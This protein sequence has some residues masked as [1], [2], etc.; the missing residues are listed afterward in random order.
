MGAGLRPRGTP[1]PESSP[2]GY[3]VTAGPPAL[4]HSTWCFRLPCL[5]GSTPTPTDLRDPL[6]V[7]L[8]TPA[9]GAALRSASPAGNRRAKPQEA[10]ATPMQATWCYPGHR[11]HALCSIHTPHTA[12]SCQD[13]ARLPKPLGWHLG[14]CQ[15]SSSPQS[16]G[17][18]G[19]AKGVAVQWAAGEGSTGPGIPQNELTCTCEVGVQPLPP[20]PDEPVQRRRAPAK[21]SLGPGQGR[22]TWVKSSW[23]LGR[24]LYPLGSG[25][26]RWV[27]W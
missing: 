8:R 19:P 10:Q 20:A 3:K 26:A 21:R 15:L 16:P 4:A 23:E 25:L 6:G 22:A 7:S 24:R 12:I 5:P 18:T 9:L 17:S 14:G 2:W 27:L 1:T 11:P 13:P